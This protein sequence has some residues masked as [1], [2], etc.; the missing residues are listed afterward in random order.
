MILLLVI[1]L[2]IFVKFKLKLFWTV[3]LELSFILNVHK[4]ILFNFFFDSVLS[5][6]FSLLF[7]NFYKYVTTE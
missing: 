4:F 5:C 3:E 2:T 1:S 6:N 7:T